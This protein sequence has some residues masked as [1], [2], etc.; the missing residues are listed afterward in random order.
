MTPDPIAAMAKRIINI[1]DPAD[2][3]DRASDKQRVRDEN[4]ELI[5]AAPQLAKAYLRQKEQLGIAIEGLK[6]SA[7]PSM[8]TYYPEGSWAAKDALAKIAACEGEK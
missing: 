1:D 4:S 2:W 8:D 3:R 7:N 5:K 6:K